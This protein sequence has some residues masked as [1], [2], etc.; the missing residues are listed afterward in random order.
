MIEFI[1]PAETLPIRNQVL[2]SGNLPLEACRFSTDD[3]PGAFHLGYFDDKRLVSIA[4]F[5]PQSLK[6][7]A[8]MGYQLRGMA[9]LASCRGSSLGK[10]LL[11]FAI[12]YLK[13]LEVDYLW[14]NARKAALR[15]YQS[16]D[17][18]VVSD[19]FIID[20]IGVHNILYLK[21]QN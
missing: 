21:M 11:V 20:D 3:L 19:E 1:S 8:G 16:I 4:S 13:T 15:F 7:Y 5:H 6:G 2:R 18:E 12:N 14:C 10:Q 17:F 9:T